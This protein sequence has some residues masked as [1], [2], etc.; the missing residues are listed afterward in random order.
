MKKILL[1]LLAV[2]L[3]LSIFGCAAQETI[4]EN[5]VA[6]VEQ[7][8]IPSPTQT[9]TSTPTEKITPTPIPEPLA[10]EEEIQTSEVVY[11][12]DS[13]EKYHSDGC[14]YLS[15]SK[16]AISLEDAIAE[17][18]TP[19]SKCDPPIL[20][21]YNAIEEEENE[22]TAVEST[23]EPTPVVEET[24][25]EEPVSETVYIT[26]SGAKYH[27]DG[28][29]YLSHSQIAISKDDAIAQGYT[30]CSRCNP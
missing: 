1:V 20:E 14:Q 11:V 12:T 26:E 3:S 15:K 8:A 9:T 17:G 29:Q 28:C 30:P 24:P 6:A 18:Y 13:G 23:P 27:R 7:T 19:C 2:L 4:A 22:N 16:N 25:Q 5:S 10:A 21:S